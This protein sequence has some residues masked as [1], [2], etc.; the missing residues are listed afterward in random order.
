MRRAPHFSHVGYL[1]R[2]YA[3]PRDTH[4]MAAIA[5]MAGQLPA[6][7]RLPCLDRFDESTNEPTPRNPGVPAGAYFG[8]MGEDKLLHRTFFSGPEWNCRQQGSRCRAH[9]VTYLELG[10]NR[11]KEGSN[12]IFFEQQYGWQGLLVEA[13]PK[14]CLLLNSSRCPERTGNVIACGAV[15]E[16]HT[17]GTL[18]IA[19]MDAMSGARSM[20]TPNDHMRAW[21]RHNPKDASW[22]QEITVPCAPLGALVHHA[23]LAAR[24]FD[25]FS[26]DVEDSEWFVLKTLDWSTF[27]FSVLVVEIKCVDDLRPSSQHKTRALLTEHGYTFFHRERANEIWGD[28]SVDWVRSGSLALTGGMPQTPQPCGPKTSPQPRHFTPAPIHHVPRLAA[29]GLAGTRSQSRTTSHTKHAEVAQTV[30]EP[31]TRTGNLAAS[32]RARRD[33]RTVPQRSDSRS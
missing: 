23:G 31:K 16:S 11:G 10:A 8:Q 28:M 13:L 18:Q 12:T 7:M 3:A 32:N 15:C 22:G 30:P 19:A 9:P 25:L 21:S 1:L 33:A 14:Y 24:R 26:L 17:N 29:V 6:D 20:G 5:A 2:K 4:H 27:R